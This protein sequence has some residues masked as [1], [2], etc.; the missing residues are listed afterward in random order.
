MTTTFNG[1]I[2][3]DPAIVA[4]AATMAGVRDA[5][6]ED[7]FISSYATLMLQVSNPYSSAAILTTG[8]LSETAKSFN[9][10]RVA[11]IEREERSQRVKLVFATPQNGDPSHVDELRTHRLD[12]PLGAA[13][14]RWLKEHKDALTSGA[15]TIRVYVNVETIGPDK[16][17]RVLNWV[18]IS[19]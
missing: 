19:G 13:Q 2:R 5:G 4:A 11:F 16:K 1:A 7:R 10:V 6:W 3:P 18:Q 9:A 8:M 14:W 12:T 15:A 17:V